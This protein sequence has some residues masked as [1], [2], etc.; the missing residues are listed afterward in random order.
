MTINANLDWWGGAMAA[1]LGRA[2]FT[3]STMRWVKA[4][5]DARFAPDVAAR[6][7][8]APV[9]VDTDLWRPGPRPLSRAGAS[10]R[11]VC[12][13]RLHASKGFDVALRALC[14]S[15]GE[16]LDA[17]LTIL[18]DGPERQAL[19]GLVAELGIAAH[20]HLSGSVAEDEVRRTLQGADVFLLPSHAEPL[21]VVV[22]EAMALGTPVIVT[23]A[24]GVT[25]IVTDGHDGLIVPPGDPAGLAQAITA[26]ARDPARRAALAAAG[27][28]SIVERFDARIGARI[29]AGLLPAPILRPTDRAR[30]A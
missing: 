30:A 1:K 19:A 14:Q 24:G 26:L 20:V 25:E 22:M 13:G 4:E 6:C 2:S 18:G 9:G 28:R 27:R 21:G 29:L 7:H 15:L 23:G 17:R 11:L 10:L 3:I 8:Y 5:V 16:G 12:V